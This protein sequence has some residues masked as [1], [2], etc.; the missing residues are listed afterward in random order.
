MSDQNE[1]PLRSEIEDQLEAY[2]TTATETTTETCNAPTPEYTHVF[3]TQTQDQNG[4]ST[5]T[6]FS[7]IESNSVNG[8]VEVE[9]DPEDAEENATRRFDL[10]SGAGLIHKDVSPGGGIG[11]VDNSSWTHEFVVFYYAFGTSV[12]TVYEEIGAQPCFNSNQ[13]PSVELMAHNFGDSFN[14]NKYAIRIEDDSQHV[15]LGDNAS[16]QISDMN[17]NN[18]EESTTDLV[19]YDDAICTL[20]DYEAV[21]TRDYQRPGIVETVGLMSSIV[22]LAAGGVA[23]LTAT[24]ALASTG[25]FLSTI[26]NGIGVI[27]AFDRPAQSINDSNATSSYFVEGTMGTNESI[28]VGSVPFTV[29]IPA[30]AS[31]G[32]DVRIDLPFQSNLVTDDQLDN[33]L[34]K[35][36]NVRDEYNFTYRLPGND[37]DLSMEETSPGFV[38]EN[39]EEECPDWTDSP[40]QAK[41]NVR[42]GG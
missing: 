13:K 12:N 34:R 37:A 3:P 14:D 26:T 18:I 42:N 11:N 24:G 2:Q 23:T 4:P 27:D 7:K 32:L 38:Y 16:Q 40:S 19:S 17:N 31:R 6:W 35:D 9:V 1:S 15:S 36:I 39:H 10:T 20:N 33:P 30:G 28:L 29:E 22:G 25:G 8:Q 21:E 41:Q 5:Q